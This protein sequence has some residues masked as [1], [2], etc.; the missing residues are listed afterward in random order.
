MNDN[1]LLTIQARLDLDLIAQEVPTQ[2]IL[3]LDVQAPVSASRQDRPRL[4]L[5][6]VLDRSGSMSGEKLEYVKKA[7]QH[8]LNLLK[9]GDRIA[10][11]AYD[12]QVTVLSPSVMNTQT[13]RADIQQKIGALQAGG[14]TYLSGG[15]L[16]GCQEVAQA[17]ENNQ[18]NRV[19]LLTDGLANEGI[20]D[21]EELGKH[22][23]ELTARGVSTSTFGVGEGFNEH[24]LEHMA[25]QGG[26][27]F[28]YIATPQ[29]IPDIF[30]RELNELASVTARQVEISLEIPAAVS[31]QVLGDWRIEQN[32]AQEGQRRIFL[33]DLISGHS[34]EVFVKLLTPS[35]SDQQQIPIKV[36]VRAVGEAGQ[37]LESK[38]EIALIYKPQ[39]LVLQA[40]P[41][42]DV[43]GRFSVVEM[44]TTTNQALKLE[45]EGRREEAAEAMARGIAA[46]APY[47]AP[48]QC[49][50]YTQL[51]ERMKEGMQ[52]SDRKDIHYTSYL[53][54]KGRA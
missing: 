29:E 52:E 49:I 10:V 50:Q 16:Q 48:E 11:I 15:W 9:E 1:R 19:L 13:I 53:R 14:N 30:L 8:L 12:N 51:S 26:G 24:L 38:A 43:L 40:E 46:A 23:R 39:E 7:A 18:L 17:V 2:R 41:S 4:N 35:S 47:L 44:A 54:R 20:T 34:Q 28:Y 42:L 25:N 37:P 33:G 5:A 31:V 36:S 6:L 3:E 32:T 27:Q 45:R 22:A 21:L